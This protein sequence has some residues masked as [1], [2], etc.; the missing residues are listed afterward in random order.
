ME[1]IYE[2]ILYT[3]LS[4]F[5]VWVRAQKRTVTK[6]EK[7]ERQLEKRISKLSGAYRR[8]H[9]ME[10]A[11]SEAEWETFLETKDK[12]T[13]SVYERLLQKLCEEVLESGDR[14][15]DGTSVFLRNLMVILDEVRDNGLFSQKIYYAFLGLGPLCVLPFFAVPLI[16]LW[17]VKSSEQL[18]IYYQGS[19]ELITITITFVVTVISYLWVSWLENQ[20]LL[21]GY[22]Y[23]IERRL[24]RNPYLKRRVNCRISRRY[25]Y[26][27]KKNEFL[28]GIQGFGN[29]REFEVRKRLTAL[30]FMGGAALV[31]IL[32]WYSSK[33]E[34]EKQIVFPRMYTL[35]L[36][37]EEV[38]FLEEDMREQFRALRKKQTTLPDVERH[39]A[40]YPEEVKQ[41]VVLFLKQALEKEKARGGRWYLFGICPLIGVM[42]YFFPELLLRMQA[43][44][45]M[46]K[47]MEEVQILLIVLFVQTQDVQ[48]TVEQLLEAMEEHA[49]V[50]RRAIEEAV[51]HFSVDWKKSIEIL[52]EQ[53]SYEPMEQ[54]CETLCLCEEV[55][56]EA[57]FAGI[58]KEREYLIK[59]NNQQRE[60]GL[61]ERAALAKVVAYVP[62]LTVLVLKLMVPFIAEGLSQLHLYGQGIGQFF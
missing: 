43:G 35:A 33:H 8:Y 49:V 36:E 16:H 44:H 7:R 38:E 31:V 11:L 13:Q 26:Y 18:S 45:M 20:N 41:T 34:S 15:K 12:G 23:R 39:Y 2:G 9:N 57:A 25:S 6:K 24:L 59:K 22:S 40:E 58:E 1:W 37:A 30:L 29:V 62:F 51:D 19:F 61:R 32:G 50:F 54:I 14:K 55:G 27:L 48:A 10:D 53:I 5:L 42:G 21:E 46:E 4:F 56:V 17:A 52:K 28:K 60:A 3:I 47:K